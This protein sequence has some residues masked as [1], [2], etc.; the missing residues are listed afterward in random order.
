MSKYQ[1]TKQR[2]RE[3]N[4]EYLRKY[5]KEYAISHK[6]QIRESRKRHKKKYGTNYGRTAYCKIRKEIFNLL[7]NKCKKCNN[8]D[9]RVLQIDHVFGGGNR[10]TEKNYYR[11][12]KRVLKEIKE[13]SNKYQLLCANCN[14]IKRYENRELNQYK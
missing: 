8:E 7:G 3:K 13:G 12:H 10:E 6:D 9:P 4:R 2:W 11:Y 14:C 1:I 5:Y